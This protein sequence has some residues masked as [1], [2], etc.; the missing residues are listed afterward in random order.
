[1]YAIVKDRVGT[2]FNVRELDPKTERSVEAVWA[3]GKA[4]LA[5]EIIRIYGPK[6]KRFLSFVMAVGRDVLLAL[7]ILE[8]GD[9]AEVVVGFWYI[10]SPCRIA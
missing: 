7:G 6:T 9:N 4:L 2:L 3:I 1:M 8:V 5:I 10:E